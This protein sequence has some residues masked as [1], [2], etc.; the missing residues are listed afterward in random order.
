VRGDGI[1]GAGDLGKRAV[2][3]GGDL[4]ILG[5]DDARDLERGFEVKVGGDASVL[6]H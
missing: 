6:N 4:G 5:V 1:D 3:G 2:D